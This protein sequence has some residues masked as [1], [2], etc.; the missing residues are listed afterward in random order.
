MLQRTFERVRRIELHARASRRRTTSRARGPTGQPPTTGANAGQATPKSGR[1]CSCEQHRSRATPRARSPATPTTSTA[2]SNPVVKK[3]MAGFER[4][5]D[6]LWAKASPRSRA[7][8]RLRRGRAHAQ[9]GAA[10]ARR[11]RRRD[12]PRGPD[13]PGRVGQAP[14]AEPR[15]PDHEGRDAS[16]SPTAS[17]SSR[18]RSRC[19]STCPTPST[20]VAEMARVARG[21]H[22]LVSVP[23]EPLWRGLNMAR[24]A[25]LKDLGNTPGPP[26][27]LVAQG[28]RRAAEPPRRRSRRSARP[29][30]GRCCS[31]GV[32]SEATAPPPTPIIRPQGAATGRGAKI[33]SIGIASTGVVTFA[34]FSVASYALDDDD[35]KAIALLWSVLFVIVSVIYRPIEQLLSRT[36]ADR[37]RA[38]ARDDHPLRTPLLI[39]AGFALV[40]LVIA[41]IFREPIQNDLLRRL[42]RRSTGCWS[43][44]CSPTRRATSRAAGSPGTSGSRSTAALV[45]LEATARLLFAVAVRDRDRRGA[46]GR[47]DGHGRGAVRLAR[48]RP[49]RVLA[50]AARERA[51]G[52]RTRRRSASPAA[53]ASRSPCCASCSP[54]RRCSTAAC[55]RST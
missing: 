18:P 27:P 43:S 24:G 9:V 48:R 30:R 39:Q 31:S 51:H 15:V 6:E 32:S 53:G 5:L 20:R 41:L 8:R 42:A 40:F 2:P 14:G 34:Y 36:I 4:T 44:P 21:G 47:R 55:S 35:Y 52:A 10:P 26:E 19:S 54:S 45:F 49:A 23:R 28:V 7:R 37:R 46:V 33:L 50:P 29:S 13:D 38:R 17:S 25:Y 12:R 22:L 3:L 16:R 1:P 11:P